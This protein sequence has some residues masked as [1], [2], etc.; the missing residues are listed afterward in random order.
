MMQWLAAS[1]EAGRSV[2]R[3]RQQ[4]DKINARLLGVSESSGRRAITGT[5]L[6]IGGRGFVGSA[7]SAVA[8]ERGWQVTIAGRSESESLA[9]SRFD[10]V[11]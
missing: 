10:L 6:I 1:R 3:R 4:A 8:Q 2:L 7:I 5:C 11:I 9:G